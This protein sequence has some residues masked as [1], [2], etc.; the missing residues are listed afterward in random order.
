[1]S[2]GFFGLKP[3][4]NTSS[5]HNIHYIQLIIFNTCSEYPF[6]ADKNFLPII[7]LIINDI[8]L[9]IITKRTVY[10]KHETVLPQPSALE[11]YL[12]THPGPRSY[13]QP[14]KYDHE[15]EH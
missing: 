7:H 5:E 14:L 13:M 15:R 6:R 4:Y 3:V 2:F 12:Q 8:W 1:M 9:L 11:E 10:P